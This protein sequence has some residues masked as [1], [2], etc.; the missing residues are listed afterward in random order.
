MLSSS[1]TADEELTENAG[2]YL[3]GAI[4]EGG[5]AVVVATPSHCAGFEAHLAAGGVDVGAARR[6][7]S[8]VCLDATRVAL[9]LTRDGR[10]DL[11]A[12]DTQFRPAILAAGEAPGPVRIYG[13]VVALLWAAGQVN[14]ALELEGLWNELGREIPFSL[15]CGYPRDLVESSQHQ[16]AVAEVCRLHTAVVG[17]PL[18]GAPV[19]GAPA[20]VPQYRVRQRAGASAADGSAAG[21]PLRRVHWADVTR[22]FAGSREDTRAAR[23]FALGMLEPWRGEQLAADTALV[24]TELATNAVL[25]AGSAFS[26]SLALSGGAIR[27]SVGD[28]LPLGPNGVDQQL[29]AVSGHG[30]GVVAAMATRWGVETRAQRQGRLGRA[31]PARLTGPLND[32]ARLIR[33]DGQ[34]RC[35]GWSRQEVVAR[36]RRNALVSRRLRPGSSPTGKMMGHSS[37]TPASASRPSCFSIAASSPVTARAPGDSAPSRSSSRR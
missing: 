17:R 13:E 14:A 5:A 28:T 3:A 21:H 35:P 31:S 20:T 22:T 24:V 34:D 15:F 29:A 11:A 25:H 37:V 19:T 8:L 12:F 33:P 1:T 18:A 4:A 32:R 16:G 9:R 26:V 30:L 27:I 2:D 36:A 23:G 10:V 7:G 6:D